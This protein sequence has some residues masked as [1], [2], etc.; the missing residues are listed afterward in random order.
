MVRDTSE[1]EAGSSVAMIDDAI[2]LGQSENA[3]R[4]VAPVLGILNSR[5]L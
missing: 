4:Y 5:G 3:A 1:L 2:H